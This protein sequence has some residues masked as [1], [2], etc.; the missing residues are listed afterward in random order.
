MDF[1]GY[2]IRLTAAAILAALVRR[3]S[4]AGGA[5]RAAR[6]GAGLLVL[7]TAF[8]PLAEVDTLAAAQSLTRSGFAV[9]TE[10]VSAEANNL[11][12]DLI[13]Q[14]AETYILD[15]ARDMDLTLSVTVE[16]RA[17][18]AYPVPWSVTIRGSFTEEQRSALSQTISQE[19]GVPE[20]RQEWWSM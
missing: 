4:P 9:T 5:G 19:L 17:D 15:K 18:G 16:T 8:G 11:L 10:D 3:L 2:L 1:K 6:L 13:S 7:L 14:E 20:D 12:S